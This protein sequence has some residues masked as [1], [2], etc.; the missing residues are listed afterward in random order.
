[1]WAVRDELAQKLC[2]G[3]DTCPELERG[4][5]KVITT[6]DWNMQ[7]VAEKWVTAGVL[8]PHQLDPEAFAAQIGVPFE[9]W[10]KKLENLQVNNGALVA[11]DYQTGET[12]AY[13][14]SAGYYRDDIS[15]PQFQPQ[16]DVLGDGWRQ[17]GSAF[18]PFNYVT[19]INN[20]TMTAASM[21][22]DVTTTFDNSS[23]Y[24]PKDYD[25]LERGPVR[26]RNALQ[27]SLNIPAVKALEMNGIDNVFATAQKLGLVFQND[28]P[29][30]GLSLTLGT[31]VNHPRDVAVAYGTIANGGTHI[32]YTT[33]LQIQDRDR[34]GSRSALRAARR[35]LG[36]Q[37]A[38]RVRDDQHPGLEHGSQ[39]EPDLGRLR[40]PGRRRHA[41]AGDAQD[42]HQ[43]RRQRPRRVRLPAAARRCRPRRGEYA[44]VVGAWNGN[45]DGS[46]VLTPQ[47]PVLSTDVAAPVWHGF[48][49]E[50]SGSWPV[51]DFVRPDG[52]VDADV[53]AWSGGKP[54]QFT[55]QTV[56]EVFI[57]GTV[58]GDDTTKV[59]M[60]VVP[61]RKRQQRPVGR[62]LRR[63][64]TDDGLPE[65]RQRRGRS[66]R[67]ARR[68][69]RLDRARQAGTRHGRWSR[70]T[71]P[72]QDE[73]HLRSALHALRQELG[74]AVRAD[75]T[76]SPRR[77][78]FARRLRL[79]FAVDRDIADHPPRPSSLT[80]RS[81]TP[82]PITRPPPPPTEPPPTVPPPTEPPTPKPTEPP[83]TIEP[84]TPPPESIAPAPS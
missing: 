35:R 22:M 20:G 67:L 5:L 41:P 68:G 50:V 26:M 60:Q 49:E 7:Q 63:H 17:P 74:R 38:G 75:D 36:R 55:T 69:R 14:G 11:M 52:I 19:G 24:T 58:P 16:F 73:L 48:T 65:P 6:L 84:P 72:D 32:G 3:A 56:N 9:P 79:A 45:S 61:R 43:Q 12:L 70:P 18:K 21:F 77:P 15:S 34:Q 33:I 10:M 42:G 29:Q 13:V 44:L 40:P 57:N 28:T 27:W 53:D 66:L 39:A 59:G 31:E 81:I 25:L 80:P 54:T 83:P 51:N 71:G 37:P 1:M 30:A 2:A 78:P 8:L 76:L 47:N 46:P 4:G 62:R 64:A 23:G 82:P